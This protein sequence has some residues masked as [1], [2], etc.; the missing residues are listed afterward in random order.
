MKRRGLR[1]LVLGGNGNETEGRTSSLIS[2]EGI[3]IICGMKSL[4]LCLALP[5]A[6]VGVELPQLA[7]PEFIDTEVSA[8]HRLE[9]PAFG[10]RGLDFRLDF[11]GTPSNNV[12]VAFGRDLDANGSLAPH[13]T[14]VIVGWECGRYFI[15]RFRTGERIEEANVGTNDLARLLAWHYDVR[16]GGKV[17]KAFTASNEVCAAFASVSTNTPAW[18]YD[19]NWNLMQ[20]TAR[21]VDVQGE[22]FEV[23]V[24][25]SGF[26][27]HLK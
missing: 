26:L 4:L 24:R 9:Q 10:L 19:R 2:R 12:E 15:E 23:D 27:I 8:T 16:K 3:D 1:S 20:L 14:D 7:A 6:A 11:N 22:R 18:L 21:G 17:L 13:E 5:L 25:T